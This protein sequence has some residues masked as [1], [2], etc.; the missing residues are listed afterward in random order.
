MPGVRGVRGLD[1]I[2]LLCC[3]GA[4]AFAP[5]SLPGLRSQGTSTLLRRGTERLSVP[6]TPGVW[7]SAVRMAQQQTEEEVVLKVKPSTDFSLLNLAQFGIESMF[8]SKYYIG[9]EE[10]HFALPL[11]PDNQYPIW[12]PKPLRYRDRL[13]FC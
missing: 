3:V 4:E 9:N 7:G 6:R 11:I 12:I 13:S 8:S 10:F 2:L 1:L 5:P